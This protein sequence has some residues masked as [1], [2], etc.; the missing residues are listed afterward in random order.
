[1]NILVC[2]DDGIFSEGLLALANILKKKGHNVIIFAPEGNRSGFSRSVSFFKEIPIKKVEIEGFLAYSVNGTPADCC[3]LGLE[4][5][6]DV[7]LVVSGINKGSNLGS[8]I[9]YSGTVN[10][11]FEASFKKVKSIAF[12]NVKFKDYKFDENAKF[13]DKYFEKLYE[14]SSPSFVLNVNIPNLTLNEIK[15]VKVCKTGHVRYNDTYVQPSKDVY[16]LVGEPIPPESDDFDSDI[17]WSHN[18][19]ATV[20]P[21]SHYIFDSKF[22]NVLKDVNF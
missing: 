12:S 16:M 8:D 5:F 4:L 18:N 1:M 2:N 14:M 10:A 19:Y 6:K 22:L 21:V 7:D 11:C 9:F 20:S 15:G 13:I 17:Y 3:K